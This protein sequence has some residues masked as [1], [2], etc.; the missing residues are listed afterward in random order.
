VGGNLTNLKVEMPKI[1]W[2]QG[3]ST[4]KKKKKERK[5]HKTRGKGSFI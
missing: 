2:P 4:Q 1:N 3:G 5:K